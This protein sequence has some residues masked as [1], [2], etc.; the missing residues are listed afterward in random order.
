MKRFGQAFSLWNLVR[1]VNL[2]EVRQSAERLPLIVL[3]TKNEDSAK[4][5]M[6]TL[7]GG[8]QSSA[9]QPGPF[10]SISF[11]LSNGQIN[12]IHKADAVLYVIE[13]DM[14]IAKSELEEIHKHVGAPTPIISIVTDESWVEGVQILPICVFARAVHIKHMSPSNLMHHVV[15]VLIDSLQEDGLHVARMMP[16]LRNA[17]ASLLVSKTSMANAE[18]AVLTNVPAIIP[19]VGNIIGATADFLVL[20]KNQIMLLYKLAAIYGRNIRS[21]REVYQEVL[22]VVGAGLVWRT[23]AREIAALVPV[24]AGAIPK[25]VIAYAGTYAIG[26][27]ASFYYGEGHRPSREKMKELY[28]MGVERARNIRLPRGKATSQEDTQSKTDV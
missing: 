26:R 4:T 10:R 11:P 3:A 25:V 28:Q 5:I 19:I 22:P 14:E 13:A 6:S 24:W 2:E 27:G 9:V 23:V 17:M 1:E 21:V 15:P 18:F 20:T 16:P 7:S 12:D 8:L